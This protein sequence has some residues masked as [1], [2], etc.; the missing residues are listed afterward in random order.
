MFEALFDAIHRELEVLDEKYADPS[1]QMTGEDLMNI[2]RMAHALKSLATYKA[3]IST[4]DG[5]PRSRTRYYR[6]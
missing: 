2:D 1:R 6:Y 5:R 4:D 3:M